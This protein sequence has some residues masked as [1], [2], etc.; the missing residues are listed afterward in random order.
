[1]PMMGVLLVG[2]ILITYLPVLTTWLP[3]TVK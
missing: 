3:R 2:V 1:L